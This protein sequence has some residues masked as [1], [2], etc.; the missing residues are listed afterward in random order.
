MHN[1]EFMPKTGCSHRD[2][3]VSGKSCRRIGAV[4]MAYARSPRGTAGLC[5]HSPQ[6]RTYALSEIPNATLSFLRILATNLSRSSAVNS[7]SPALK[8]T[9]NARL[10]MVG[11]I[12]A[13]S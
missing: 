2:N 12:G 11:G 10:F 4:T 9:V 1:N 8:V 5:S 13:P 6:T 7:S 3:P